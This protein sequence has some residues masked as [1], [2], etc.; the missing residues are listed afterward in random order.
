MSESQGTSVPRFPE[1]SA[2][3]E[4]TRA[5]VVDIIEPTILS[6]GAAGDRMAVRLSVT[7]LLDGGAFLGV[8]YGLREADG[9]DGTPGDFWP[10]TAIERIPVP[11]EAWRLLTGQPF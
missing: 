8:E 11:A 4:P 10:E 5:R 2:S 7:P 9:T 1:S 6:R 3:T